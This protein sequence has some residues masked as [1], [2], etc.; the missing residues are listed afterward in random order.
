MLVHEALDLTE[1]L[2]SPV[3]FQ[4]IYLGRK[5]DG[6]MRADIWHNCIFTV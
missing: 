5:I 2:I 4:N 3:G 6:I 1:M